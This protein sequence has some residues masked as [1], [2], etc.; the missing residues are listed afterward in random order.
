[1]LLLAACSQPEPQARLIGP[2][3]ADPQHVCS[4]TGQEGAIFTLSN[5]EVL[6]EETGRTCDYRAT[7]AALLAETAP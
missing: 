7:R 5:G 3:I 6:I 4:V 1:M 2:Q